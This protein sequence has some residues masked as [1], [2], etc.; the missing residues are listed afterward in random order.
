MLT[1]SGLRKRSNSRPY[2]EGVDIGDLH[3]VADQAS[4][5]RT[6]AWSDGNALLFREA[7]EIPD[8]Q[9]VAGEL[10]LLDDLD[11]RIQSAGVFG[12]IVFQAAGVAQSFE[13]PTPFF[14]SL[15][16]DVFE[17]R[18]GGVFSG[19]VEFRERFFD[20]FEFDAAALGDLPRHLDRLLKLA[21][22]GSHLIARFDKLEQSNGTGASTGTASCRP[23]RRNRSIAADSATG[24]PAIRRLIFTRS[25]HEARA[26]RLMP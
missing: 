10:H 21:E 19:D 26:G 8:D 13:T 17:I 25:G 2:C 14:E 16:R 6:A 15:A 24:R 4:G 1:R 9:E 7:D 20:L 18:I 23:R 5:G 22:Q 3:G 11:L 12:E